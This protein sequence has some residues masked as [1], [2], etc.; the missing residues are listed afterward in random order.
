MRRY[1]AMLFLIGSAAASDWEAR[2]SRG[3]ALEREGRYESAAAAFEGALQEAA[4]IQMP[5]TWNNLGVVYRALDRPR[6]AERCYRRAI[7]YYEQRP[8]L[9]AALATTLENLA[10]LHLA[11]GQLSK[12]EPL[13]RRSYEMRIRVLPPGHPAIAESLQGLGRLEQERRHTALAE[14]YYREALAIHGTAATLHNLGTLLASTGRVGE[15]RELYERA[16]AM[17][18]QRGSAHPDE[19]TVLRHLAELRL[20]TNRRAAEGAEETQRTQFHR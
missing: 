11:L 5:V 4:G 6:D 2:F 17:Y 3:E 12:A 15:A 18:R 9:A 20:F 8:D 14:K 7:A 16:L 19:A 10:A 1:V 13:Y